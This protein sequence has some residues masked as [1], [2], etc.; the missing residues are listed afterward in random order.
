MQFRPCIDIHNGKVK[1]IV[2]GSLRDEGDVATENFVSEQD[3]AYFAKLYQKDGIKGGHI[4]LLNAA[5]SP[6]YKETKQQAKN[7]L[8]AYPGG[9]QVGGGIHDGNAKEFLDA[10]ASHVIVTS[11]VFREG[12]IFYDNLR[13]IEQAVGKEHL[14]LDLSC[15][16]REDSYYIV[17][18]RWQ[19]F[20]EEKVTTE[21]LDEL[22]GYCDEFLIHAVDVEGKSKGIE[23]ELVKL[24]GDWGKIPVTYAGGVGSFDDLEQLKELGKGHLNVTIGSALDLFG[25]P[26]DYHSVLKFMKEERD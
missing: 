16:K 24:L 19:K 18:D 22:S 26:M 13:K 3:A 11:F 2:G 20:T 21:L 17:T 6:Y 15:R 5:D 8:Q 14:V 4:I 10:G 1:Q 23:T 7:A 12:R 25:G 9:L